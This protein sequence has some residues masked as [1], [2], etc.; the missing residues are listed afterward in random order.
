MTTYKVVGST[1]ALEIPMG[2]PCEGTT[3]TL[4]VRCEDEVYAALLCEHLKDL[5][6][7]AMKEIRRAAYLRGYRDGKAKRRRLDLFSWADE[8]LEWELKE[9]GLE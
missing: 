7:K 6:M 9:A 3:I 4:D 2:H 1:V 8:A 5:R